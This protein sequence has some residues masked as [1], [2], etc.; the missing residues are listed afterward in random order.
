MSE[1]TSVWDT[2]T[3]LQLAWFWS[4]MCL[5]GKI[6]LTLPIVSEYSKN[7]KSLFPQEMRAAQSENHDSKQCDSPTHYF[8]VTPNNVHL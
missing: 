7:Q 6:Q 2:T 3:A 4:T 5:D 1:D 8:L